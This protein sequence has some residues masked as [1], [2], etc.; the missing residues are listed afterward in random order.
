MKWLFQKELLFFEYIKNHWFCTKNRR[1]CD[2]LELWAKVY[3]YYL[4]TYRSLK[5]AFSSQPEPSPFGRVY[6]SILT[7][8]EVSHIFEC[9][10]HKQPSVVESMSHRSSARPDKNSKTNLVSITISAFSLT[11][12]TCRQSSEDQINTVKPFRL[13]QHSLRVIG[14]IQIRRYLNSPFLSH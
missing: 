3:N 10:N 5:I 9:A 2:L 8:T 11:P 12:H 1:L 14:V 7:T 13:P 4:Y 6:C